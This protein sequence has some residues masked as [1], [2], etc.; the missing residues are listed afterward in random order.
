[1]PKPAAKS[2]TSTSPKVIEMPNMKSRGMRFEI[3]PCPDDRRF[4]LVTMRLPWSDEFGI[5]RE[6][7]SQQQRG[8]GALEGARRFLTKIFGLR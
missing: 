3:A 5:T 8:R 6:D 4:I 1:M 7:V 2:I